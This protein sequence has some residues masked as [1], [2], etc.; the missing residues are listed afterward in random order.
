MIKN[1]KNKKVFFLSIFIIPSLLCLG[2]Y[3]FAIRKPLSK[4]K[5]NI[6]VKLPHYG[7]ASINSS[8]DSIFYCIPEFLFT[9]QYNKK[10]NSESLK[11]KIFIICVSN[12]NDDVSNQMAAQLYR[13]Q[14]KLSY[15][16]KDF[17][18]INVL[19]NIEND[20]IQNLFE[21]AKKVHAEEKIW[22]VVAGNKQEIFN[23]FETNNVISNN[24]KSLTESNEILLIDRNKNIRGH[25]NGTNLKEVNRLID[26]VMVLAAE[27]GK[28]KNM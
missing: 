23:V 16:K 6:F 28:I 20:T 22:H 13:V 25:Y 1:N 9:N 15:L 12:Y 8:G 2:F 7:T 18:I 24:A 5:T 14:D 27:Y 11:D 10:V 4:G 19:K 21:F 17:K 3:Y 26:E